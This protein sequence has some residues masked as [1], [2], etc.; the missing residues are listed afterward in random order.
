M[1]GLAG[2]K[3]DLR[4][5]AILLGM[6]VLIIG[7]GFFPNALLEYMHA[8]VEH[9]VTDTQQAFAAFAVN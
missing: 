6:A 4:E 3:L 9:L 2:E 7:I 5:V 1:R 8:T